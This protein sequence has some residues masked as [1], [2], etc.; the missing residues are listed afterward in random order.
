MSESDAIVLRRLDAPSSSSELEEVEVGAEAEIERLEAEIAVKRKR[1]VA[2][3]GELRRR[4]DRATDWRQWV[5]AHP[6]A[7][8]AAAVTV[9]F[10]L[11]TRGGRSRK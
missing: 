4:V 8:I 1:V 11:G 5:R 2:S 7:W 3:F 6:V 9:G 10:V